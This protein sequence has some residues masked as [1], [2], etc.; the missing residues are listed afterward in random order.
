MLFRNSIRSSNRKS[1]NKLSLESLERRLLLAGD[2]L[3]AGE[4]ILISEFSADSTST[5]L[6]RTRS[7]VDQEFEGD[8][9]SPDWIELLNVSDKTM[10][11]SGMHLTDDASEPQKWS[12]PADTEIEAGGFVVVFASGENVSNPNLDENGLLHTNFRLSEEGEY[13]AITD[14]DGRVIHEFEGSFPAQRTDISYAASMTES[15]I[16]D[17]GPV[18]YL[19]PVDNSLEPDWRMPGF[20]HPEL[21]SLASGPLGYDRG[22]GDVEPAETIGAELIDR[23]RIDFSRGSMVILESRPFTETGRVAEWSF[24]SEKTNS[25]TPLIFKLTENG[26]EIV[27]VGTART[28]DGSGVQSFAFDLLDGSDTVDANGYFFGVKDGDNESDASGSIVWANSKEDSV[29][30]FNGP[31]SGSISV[32][33]SFDGGRS[34]GR[35]FSVQAT[36]S[37]TL[38]GPFESDISTAMQ[39]A[40]T[41]YARFP[42][43]VDDPQT[44]QLL[45]LQA[46]YDDGFVAYLNGQE[47]ARRNAPNEIS[48]DSLATANQSLSDA[49]R[50]ELINVSHAVGNLN[51]GENVLSFHALNDK[52]NGEEFVIDARMIAAE[53][54]SVEMGYTAVATPGN[55]N[56]EVQSGFVSDLTFSHERGLYEQP[57]QLELSSDG[58]DGAA[59]YYTIDGTDPAPDNPSSVR[60]DQPLEITETTILRAGSFQDGWLP[61]RVQSHTFIF[62]ADVKSQETLSTDVTDNPVW[63]PQFTDSLRS[64]PTISLMTAEPITVEG[65]FFTSAELIYPDDTQGFQVDAGVEVYGG[66]AVSFPKRSMR[67]SFKNIYGPATL[68]HDV[69]QDGGVSEFDQ[70]LLRPGSHDAPFWNGAEGDGNYL[71]NRWVSDRQLEMGHPAPRG[72]FVHLYLNG[73]YWGQFHLMERP[74]AAFMASHFGGQPEDYDALNRGNPIN[75]DDVAW[76]QLLDAIDVSYEEVQK[77]LDVENY[78][79]YILLQFYGGNNIDWRSDSN[80]MAGRRREPGAGF[81]FFAWDSDLIM[82]IGAEVDIVNFGGPGFLWTRDGGVQQ[83][84]E[85]LKL[86]AERAQMHL[87]DGGIFTDE[88]VIESINGLAAD[89]RPGIVA[90]TARWGSGRYTPDTW[91]A[92]VQW[93]TDTYTPADGP[94]R[95]DTVIEQMR[96]AGFFP[97]S[98]RPDFVVEDNPIQDFVAPGSLLTM[99]VADGSIYYTLDGSDPWATQPVSELTELISDSSTMNVHV[100]SDDSLQQEW[101]QIGFNDEEWASGTSGIGFDT[102]DELDP[103]IGLDIQEQMKGTNASA[104]LRVPFQIES[105]DQ[106]D[107]LKLSLQYDDGFVAYLNGTE[108]ARRN[109]PSEPTWNS[110]SSRVRANIE[111]IEFESFNLTREKGLLVEG[112]NILAIHALNSDPNNVD[113]LNAPRLIAGKVSNPGIAETAILY[114]GPVNVGDTVTIRA[115]TLMADQWSTERTASSEAQPVGLRISEVM[116]HP[117]DSTAVEIAAGI[118]DSDD[119][120]FIELVNISNEPIDLSGVQFEQS[121]V[122]GQTEGVAFKFDTSQIKSVGPGQ[123]VLVVENASAFSKRYGDNLPVAGAWSGGLSNN[124]EQITVT[125]NGTILQQFRYDDDWYPETD[126]AGS[127]LQIIDVENTELSDWNN[128]IRW[129]ASSQPGGTPGRGDLDF[130]PGDSN[131]DGVFN[132][133][134][135]IHVF[136]IGEYEDGIQNNSTFEDGDWNGDGDFDSSDIVHAFQAGT[137]VAEALPL[138]LV[139]LE[140]IARA[141]SHDTSLDFSHDNQR[142]DESKK[143]TLRRP[144]RLPL[145]SFE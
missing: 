55:W 25:V 145:V 81:Q 27:G 83:H 123:R 91:E 79:D 85:F 33:Q 54:A 106:I 132:S 58:F 14:K 93:M 31:L 115:R 56:S 32:G 99:S 101:I 137:Y 92:A 68:N 112:E 107:T 135:L 52:Q 13:L 87:L 44:I 94:S 104:Y 23:S 109:A 84:P 35:A 100:P 26:H 122:A 77:Y 140:D 66:T 10:N 117:S 111:A 62:P 29:L 108:V 45:E 118:T 129:R 130:I 67:L 119:F 76:N 43:T 125:H 47:I 128:S 114:E 82:R 41:L 37:A 40:S 24:Y 142:E 113:L 86:L 105:L 48:F 51:A 90:E 16:V 63:G 78:A 126:G 19:V 46:R 69:F 89:M 141:I 120:E 88:R 98:D 95:A 34:F 15:T 71:R 38:E 74:N 70:L 131:R 103:L 124:A 121:D 143:R 42:F 21:V 73:V 64:Q 97:L 80:W 53:F 136:Q 4:S 36:T 72:E 65:E 5:L 39:N 6:T 20:S 96:H 3:A 134:D 49:N 138:P 133:S 28:S 7:S 11:L 57:F 30:R 2:P 61:S 127:S 110:R 144:L 12:F 1:L 59:I 18:E 60:Y 17:G 139:A 9:E 22:G 75:G 102:N 8:S 50:Y 116:Y